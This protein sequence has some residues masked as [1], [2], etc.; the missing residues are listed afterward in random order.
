MTTRF[1]ILILVILASNFLFGQSNHDTLYVFVGQKLSIS[2]LPRPP[3]PPGQMVISYENYK[4]KY[5]VIKSIYG[6]YLYKTIEFTASDHYGVPAFSKSKYALLFVFVH[7]GKFHHIRYQYFDVYK[8][9]TG[10]LG[11]LWRPIL[12]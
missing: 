3:D 5:K 4:A 6:D 10:R 11:K 8:T 1:L 12:F 2:K 7:D 9:K